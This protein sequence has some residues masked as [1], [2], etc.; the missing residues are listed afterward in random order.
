[1]GADQAFEEDDS[2]S[3]AI[4]PGSCHGFASGII[5]TISQTDDAPDS[6]LDAPS[7]LCYDWHP[8]Y[9]IEEF[10]EAG[11]KQTKVRIRLGLRVKAYCKKCQTSAQEKRNRNR[12]LILGGE[13]A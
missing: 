4:A 1:V 5:N 3:I 9:Q 2:P 10:R 12:V 8:L 11:N 13:M 7:R 6:N